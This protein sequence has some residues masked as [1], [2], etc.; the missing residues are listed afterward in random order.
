MTDKQVKDTV[1]FVRLPFP[2]T[3]LFNIRTG[4]LENPRSF[5]T[6][7]GFIKFTETLW[8]ATDQ[9]FTLTKKEEVLTKVVNMFYTLCEIYIFISTIYKLIDKL[10]F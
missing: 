4:L 1:S 10:L 3:R 5:L 9:V 8:N 7:T 2:K 6:F